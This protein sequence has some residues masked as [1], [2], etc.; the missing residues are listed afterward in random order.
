[1]YFYSVFFL[2]CRKAMKKAL[3]IL[4]LLSEIALPSAFCQN[5]KTSLDNRHSVRIGWGDMIYESAVFR[6]SLNGA[7]TNPDVL[8][9]D[10]IHDETFDFGYT[11]HLFAE[12]QYRLTKVTSIGLQA[13]LEGIFWK[14][15]AFDRYHNLAS[16]TE[17]IRNWDLDLLLTARFTYFER[18]WVRIYSGLGFGVLLAFDNQG[19]FGAAP[20]FNL[21]WIGMEVGKGPWG[22]TLEVGSLNALANKLTIYQAFSRIL[23]FSV[24]Y[25]W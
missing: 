7:W 11:G 9:A 15:G 5:E 22:G 17:K 21:N 19:G 16:P 13:D 20:A 3:A 12:Y 6:P 25:K 1:M 8:P 24:Y 14:E 4:L 18:P 23:S 10:Y 2:K